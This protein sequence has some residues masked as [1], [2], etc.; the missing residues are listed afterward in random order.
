MLDIYRTKKSSEVRILSEADRYKEEMLLR[1][2]QLKAEMTSADPATKT[3]LEK[4]LAKLRLEMHT[5]YRVL[6]R[7]EK[8]QRA[9][10]RKREKEFLK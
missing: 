1:I 9:A 7:E 6:K 4:K 5:Q 8:A 2:S 10:L 3:A